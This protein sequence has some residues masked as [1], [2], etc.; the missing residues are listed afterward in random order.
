MKVTDK[1]KRF[2][3]KI[4]IYKQ[5]REG[6]KA[7]GKKENYYQC[8]KKISQWSKGIRRL[9]ERTSAINQMILAIDDFFEVDIKSRVLN[10]THKLAR[11]VFYK[12][13]MENGIQGAFLSLALGRTRKKTASECRL[14]F[15]RSFP[16]NNGNK[17]TYHKFKSYMAQ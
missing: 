10:T 5:R 8:T 16:D 2:Y 12:Y 9:D 11:N 4:Y 7:E 1:R 6:Y 3:Q 17:T 15:T 14:R 13:G